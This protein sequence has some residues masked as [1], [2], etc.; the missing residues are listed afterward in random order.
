MRPSSLASETENASSGRWL[1][2]GSGRVESNLERLRKSESLSL[3]SPD[4]KAS[5]NA[6]WSG[7]S[8][9]PASFESGRGSSGMS[10]GVG[11]GWA[12][13][14]QRNPAKADAQGHVPG[15]TMSYTWH[16]L[17]VRQ[18]VIINSYAMHIPGIYMTNYLA[19]TW[20]VTLWCHMPGICQ[21]YTRHM[22]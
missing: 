20:H 13:Y 15:I 1:G 14:C 6:C 3:D 12:T 19:Y 11:S 2:L 7:P 17:D 9:S 4:M 5:N 8:E 16:I 18:D 21:A 22:M 10:S